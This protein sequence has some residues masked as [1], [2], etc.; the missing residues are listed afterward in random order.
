MKKLFALLFPLAVQA[1]VPKTIVVEHFTNSRCSVCASQ[2]P[3][4]YQILRNNPQVKHIA[5]HPTSP[6]VNCQLAQHNA[7][8]ND[9]RT[10]YY[11]LYGSTPKLAIQGAN[12]S[13]NPNPYQNAALYSSYQ[14]QTSAFSL[15]TSQQKTTDSIYLRVV[16]RTEASHSLSTLRL[17]AGVAED[18]VFFASPNGE[19]IHHDVFRRSFFGPQGLIVTPAASV[20]DSVV[21]ESKLRYHPV[22]NVNRIF[23]FALLQNATTRVLEQAGF[24]EPSDNELITK[25]NTLLS[26]TPCFVLFPNPSALSTVVRFEREGYRRIQILSGLGN[27]LLSTS[28]MRAE[29]EI[30]RNLPPGLYWVQ[31]T[32]AAGRKSVKWV[33]QY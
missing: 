6:Y 21:L 26:E 17:Y 5:F 9:A 24:T 10:N 31:V 4:F 13:Y 1:Q 33:K 22:W 30:G 23:S 29:I 12:I 28:T 3:S 25:G 18:T 11:G 16:V 7:V 8:E 20:G 15:K 32:T 27:V 14:G 2:N 19:T